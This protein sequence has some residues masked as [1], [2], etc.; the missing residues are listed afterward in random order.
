MPYETDRLILKPTSIEDAAFILDVMN[1]PKWIKYIGDRKVYTLEAAGQY[2]KDKML[3]Q[4]LRLGY[5]NNTVIRKSDGVKIGSCGL[6][7]R[8]GLAGVDIG[9][10]FL[11]D[12]EGQ[13]YA[14]EAAQK[15]KS[16]AIE[17]WGIKKISAITTQDNLS[18]QR[19]LDK[20]GLHSQGL[21]TLPGDTEELLLYVLE[22]TS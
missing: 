2:I 15:I 12:Y 19:L 9:F 5:S 8:A 13:G 6:Y 4:Y 17:E 16:L 7:D 14:Y 22:L 20:L 21:T 18:S 3:P 10:A 11:P 1:T